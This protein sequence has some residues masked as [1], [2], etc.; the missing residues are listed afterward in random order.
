MSV[1]DWYPVLP[2]HHHHHHHL[3]CSSPTLS[4]T[5]TY[6]LPNA[7]NTSSPQDQDHL[8]QE[9][10]WCVT[11][12][13]VVMM[14]CGMGR[15]SPA[16]SPTSSCESGDSGGSMGGWSRHHS[17]SGGGPSSWS[18]GAPGTT[19]PVL[20]A[21]SD[22]S[23]P[24]CSLAES[25]DRQGKCR[26]RP[27]KVVGR[28]VLKRRRLAANARERRRMNGLNDAFDR[29]REHIPAL[30]G[31]QKLSKFETLQMAQTYISAL[32]DLLQ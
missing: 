26:R 29:L 12:G 31:D 13:D 14:P 24:E 6:T 4:T 17:S 18:W 7:S 25:R 11:T 1:S 32:V 8:L 3:P 19:H 10:P 22:L 23:S 20:A 15:P 30:S 27:P 2:T 9:D 16:C 28:D 21:V 5:T